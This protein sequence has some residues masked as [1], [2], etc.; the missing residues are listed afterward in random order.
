VLNDSGNAHEILST[1]ALVRQRI[2]DHCLTTEIRKHFPITLSDLSGGWGQ[3]MKERTE[4][5]D[6]AYNPIYYSTTASSTS[7]VMTEWRRSYSV[8]LLLLLYMCPCCTTTI[9]MENIRLLTLHISLADRRQHNVAS[10]IF[11]MLSFSWFFLVLRWCHQNVLTS[12]LAEHRPTFAGRY[13]TVCSLIYWFMI[14]WC[15]CTYINICCS[16]QQLQHKRTS[17]SLI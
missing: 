6:F 17:H 10:R 1:D 12:G 11:T 4:K 5:E 2:V 7:A 8:C 3:P 9:T 15:V 14:P 13:G 16:N